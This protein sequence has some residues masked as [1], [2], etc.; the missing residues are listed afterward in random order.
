MSSL[1]A[2]YHTHTYRCHHAEGSD[3]QFVRAAID[4]DLEILGFSDHMPI[5]NIEGYHRLS[6][7]DR[8]NEEEMHDY[9]ASIRK[10]KSKYADRLEI[11][12]AFEC[13]WLADNVEHLKRLRGF[14]DYLIFSNH[15][16]FGNSDYY[17]YTYYC[18]DENLIHYCEETE[19]ALSSGL[20]SIFAHPE[21]FMTNRNSFNDQCRWAAD[22]LAQ[23]CVKYD[24]AMEINI[25]GFERIHRFDGKDQ[26]IYPIPEFWQ[27][28]SK[29]PIK[30][31]YGCDAHSP[32]EVFRGERIAEVRAYLG[33]IDL[34]IIDRLEV[35]QR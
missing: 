27:I 8:M 20:F 23:V 6:P 25:K 3:E 14:S 21:Y 12:T 9:L 5:P 19:E 7:I 11:L 18:D 1:K 4:A 32:L 30:A 2:N 35:K 24:V 31:I 29:Y 10:L 16:R 13:E 34:K 15:E 17:D 28:A 26:P 33:D 22:H